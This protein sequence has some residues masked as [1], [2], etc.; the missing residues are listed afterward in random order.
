MLVSPL[1]GLTFLLP[2][3]RGR[4]ARLA[5][6]ARKALIN[7]LNDRKIGTDAPLR[8]VKVSR[9]PG[10][11]Q[12]IQSYAAASQTSPSQWAASSS[13]PVGALVRGPATAALTVS[14]CAVQMLC[15]MASAQ[16]ASNE[17]MRRHASNG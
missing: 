6:A 12:T 13:A 7:L 3:P 1:F 8:C 10:R 15:D 11:C 16:G 14:R 9:P 5:Q 2:R 4:T 17:A